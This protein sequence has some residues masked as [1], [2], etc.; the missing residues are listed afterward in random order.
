[1]IELYVRKNKLVYNIRPPLREWYSPWLCRFS[2]FATN[3]ALGV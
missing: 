3:L 2:I 1:M